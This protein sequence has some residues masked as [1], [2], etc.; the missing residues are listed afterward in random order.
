[1]T[2]VFRDITEGYPRFVFY[3]L[4]GI[5]ALV[6]SAIRGRMMAARLLAGGFVECPP[7][8]Q[9]NRVCRCDDTSCRSRRDGAGGIPLFKLSLLFGFLGTLR[10]FSALPSRGSEASGRCVFSSE[11]YEQRHYDR[12]G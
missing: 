5:V 4:T 10:C 12:A 9:A 7:G 3:N 11:E 6:I 1:M 2:V 8:S